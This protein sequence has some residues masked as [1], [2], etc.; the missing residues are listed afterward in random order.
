VKLLSS[1]SPLFRAAVSTLAIGSTLKPVSA[2]PDRDSFARMRR[3]LLNER[4][5]CP[6]TV[7][8][9]QTVTSRTTLTQTRTV[10]QTR[11]T[12]LPRT[13]VTA[14]ASTVTLPA[15]T[16]TQPASTVTI[17]L[18]STTTSTTTATPQC[19]ASSDCPAPS[20]ECQVATCNQGT[21]GV[22]SAA[23]GTHVSAQN[24]G[25][26]KV[27]VCD[28]HGNV[29]TVSDDNDLPLSPSPCLTS[30]CTNGVPNLVPALDGT[31]CGPDQTCL[32][33]VCQ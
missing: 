5:I 25:D 13:T 19:Q 33:G 15:S 17:T 16:I 6:V 26:C 27:S 8:R 1:D 23:A 31:S 32:A 22:S 18:T 12:T 2:A 28:G 10:T 3:D 11:T 20:N 29:V 7:T 14:P 24:V 4:A 30:H 9:T 21:C